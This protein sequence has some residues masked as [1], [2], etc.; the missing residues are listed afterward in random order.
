VRDVEDVMIRTCAGNGVTPSGV[1]DRGLTSLER[2]PGRRLTV[3][4]A[5]VLDCC[6]AGDEPGTAPA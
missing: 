2:R 5:V 1:K 4:I 6:L 3:H